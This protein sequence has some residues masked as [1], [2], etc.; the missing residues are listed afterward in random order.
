MKRIACSIFRRLCGLSGTVLFIHHYRFLRE[1]AA[2]SESQFALPA[3]G[4]HRSWWSTE[5]SSKD[6]AFML[7][8]MRSYYVMP[9]RLPDIVAR[10][11]DHTTG[12][13]ERVGIKNIGYWTEL[14]GRNDLLVYIIA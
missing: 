13:F 1:S 3:A 11:R 9:G 10:F 4:R 2:P 8:E 5:T 7:Y 6:P 12:I 14:V